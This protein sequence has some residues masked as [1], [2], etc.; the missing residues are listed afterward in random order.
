MLVGRQD[1]DREM[2]R[3]SKVLKAGCLPGQAPEHERRT[4]HSEYATIRKLSRSGLVRIEMLSA[5]F[6]GSTTLRQ[7]GRR[8]P[9]QFAT[10]CM[11]EVKA[12]RALGSSLDFYL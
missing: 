6:D 9:M 5:A 3:A 7:S 4:I 12:P 2:T 1:V 8:S 11:L 10:A